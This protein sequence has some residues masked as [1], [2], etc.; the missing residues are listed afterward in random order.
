MFIDRCQFLSAEDALTV[1]NRRTI[2]FNVNANDL[3]LRDNRATRFR[4]FGLIA[5]QNNI[6][7]GNHFFQ[8][9]GVANGVRSAG[10]I[11][12]T[13]NTSSVIANNYV[14]N[15]FIEWTNGRMDE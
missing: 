10:L 12:A 13:T 2:G 14:D 15:C 5:G 3:K 9:D 11:M 8:G 7:T 4:H 6:I 1:P